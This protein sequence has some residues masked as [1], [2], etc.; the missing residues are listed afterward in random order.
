MSPRT[1]SGRADFDR[2]PSTVLAVDRGLPLLLAP[3]A[4]RPRFVLRLSAQSLVEESAHRRE[5][6]AAGGGGA[7]GRPRG[8][9]DARA[10]GRPLAGVDA[11]GDR[12]VDS[13]SVGLRAAGCLFRG[14]SAIEGRFSVKAGA[15]RRRLSVVM[16]A[17]VI[18]A[19]TSSTSEAEDARRGVAIAEAITRG[20]EWLR[21]SQARDGSWGGCGDS[22]SEDAE[23]PFGGVALPTVPTALAAIALL[24]AGAPPNDPAVRKA[25]RWLQENRDA[26]D[27][28]ALTVDA[29]LQ[30]LLLATLGEPRGAH[31]EAGLGADGRSPGT[32]RLSRVQQRWMR[33]AVPE[34]IGRAGSQRADGGFG[35]CRD[36]A[37][38]TDLAA[39]HFATM[40]LCAAARKGAP[41]DEI[42]SAWSDRCLRFL[43]E[44]CEA[45]GASSGEGRSK[46]DAGAD[47]AALVSLSLCRGH[48]E[49]R[50]GGSTDAAATRA[51]EAGTARIRALLEGDRVGSADARARHAHYRLWSIACAGALVDR[52][53]LGK[54][55]WYRSLEDW[56][57]AR[58]NP[59][60]SWQ[61]STTCAPQDVI[62]TGFA[63]L[64]LSG[65]WTPPLGEQPRR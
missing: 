27:E 34:L 10:G 33:D 57:L 54:S 29:A 51:L 13:G 21:K 55:C 43:T 19:R 12:C 47:A 46:R 17:I 11:R 44:S 63:I 50:G 14:R 45:S 1:L 16:V 49:R 4:A 61:D 52:K 25:V 35:A 42:D 18:P 60:G 7:E 38:R 31:A 56:L 24:S 65:P 48:M 36:A 62:G 59:N 6:C 37:R 5:S 26:P 28:R 20:V 23:V 32:P 22:A 2:A 3:V 15:L 9:A 30:I 64:I 53:L 8:A 40:A 39:T 41:V 58:Q